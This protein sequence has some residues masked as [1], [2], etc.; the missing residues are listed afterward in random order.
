MSAL[1]EAAQSVRA[2]QSVVARPLRFTVLAVFRLP[3]I[4]E[5]TKVEGSAANYKEQQDDHPERDE[6]QYIHLI[7]L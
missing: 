7:G 1:I 5:P 3:G 2:A 4:I 6:D